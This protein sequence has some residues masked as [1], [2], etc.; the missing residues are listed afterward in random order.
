MTDSSEKQPYE[1]REI[2]CP[3]LG[4]QVT[5][6]Y[7]VIEEVGKPCRRAIR[8]WS[9]YLDAEEFFRERLGTEECNNWFGEPPKPKVVTLVELIEQARKAMDKEKDE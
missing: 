6:R 8:C 7:C 9:E 5:F 4:G 1:E 2:R 3:K